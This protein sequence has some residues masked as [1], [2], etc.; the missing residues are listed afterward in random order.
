[1]FLCI[2]IYICL[3]LAGVYFTG[4]SGLV[5]TG[6]MQWHKLWLGAGMPVGTMI[7]RVALLLGYGIT[8]TS[9]GYYIFRFKEC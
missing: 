9:V 1:M 7:S 4:L 5:F 6:Y 8:F 3:K 2:I